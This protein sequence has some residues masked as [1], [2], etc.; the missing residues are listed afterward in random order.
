M[1]TA[2]VIL[3]LYAALG[4]LVMTIRIFQGARLP[5]LLALSHGALA[6]TALVLV[7][8]TAFPPGAAPLLK[9]AAAALVLAAL[10]GFFLLSFHVR[11]K[12]HP[13]A[14]VAVHALVATVGVAC[15]LEYWL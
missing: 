10:G 13:L 5:V 7:L 2:S 6:T 8:L 9:Y 1:L 3:L 14:T 15:L 12:P 11:G 4:G